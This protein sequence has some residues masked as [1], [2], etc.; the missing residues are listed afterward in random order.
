[1]GM[2]CE[3]RYSI[4]VVVRGGRPRSD[5]EVTLSETTRLLKNSSLGRV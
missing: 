3:C 1:M 2:C 5:E 4:R